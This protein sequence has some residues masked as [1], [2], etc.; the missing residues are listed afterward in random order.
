MEL[1]GLL[2]PESLAESTRRGQCSRRMPMFITIQSSSKHT[3][4]ELELDS[5]ENPT[6]A[7]DILDKEYMNKRFAAKR[8]QSDK[9]QA[10][11]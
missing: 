9:L 11:C 7:W 1:L 4:D 6:E 10:N 5:G 3:S 8:L 2:E